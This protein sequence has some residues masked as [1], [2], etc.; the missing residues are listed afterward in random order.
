LLYEG[1]EMDTA[2]FQLELTRGVVN[3]VYWRLFAPNGAPIDHGTAYSMGEAR[4]LA[5]QAAFTY[6]G[7]LR[8][9]EAM[10]STETLAVAV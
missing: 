10:T 6:L 4:R 9:Q 3:P 8:Q 1:R 2:D 5:R 7:E